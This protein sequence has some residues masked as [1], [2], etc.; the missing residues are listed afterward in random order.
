VAAGGSTDDTLEIAK[1]YRA[2][3][4]NNPLKT[5]EAG[6]PWSILISCL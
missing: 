3:I 4:Y 6:K 5:G 2:K 1:K